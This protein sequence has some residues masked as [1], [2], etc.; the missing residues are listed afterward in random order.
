VGDSSLHWD[1]TKRCEGFIGQEDEK[2]RELMDGKKWR[3][4]MRRKKWWEGRGWRE[5]MRR[6]GGENKREEVAGGR[7]CL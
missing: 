5:A 1:T 7:I 6:N 4:L 3:T 2:W